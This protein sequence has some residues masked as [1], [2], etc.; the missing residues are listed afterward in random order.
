ME[1][2]KRFFI[3]RTRNKT[4]STSRYDYFL[5]DLKQ[6]GSPVKF[7][8]MTSQSIIEIINNK[9]YLLTSKNNELGFK[10]SKI[11]GIIATYDT[12]RDVEH[13]FVIDDYYKK[14]SAYVNK[15]KVMKR[16]EIQ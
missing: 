15:V 13:D 8:H 12:L 2:A 5:Y 9:Y 7:Y 14:V 4:D 1:K 6:Y 10:K 11:K 16:D 3:Q